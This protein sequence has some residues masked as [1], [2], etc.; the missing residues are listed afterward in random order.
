[1]SEWVVVFVGVMSVAL[2]VMAVVQV[3]VARALLQ[4][5]QQMATAVADLRKEVRP[6]VDKANRIADDAARATALAVS[7]VERVDRM[8]ANATIRVDETLNM[9][10]GMI[11]GP[12]RH[13]AAV[14]AGIRAALSAL[15]AWQE[16]REMSREEEDALFVG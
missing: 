10:Q 15:R 3:L 5:S 6:L 1:V 14:I 9:V 2:A 7:Q 13:G 11:V 16:R 8:L 12:V 4:A